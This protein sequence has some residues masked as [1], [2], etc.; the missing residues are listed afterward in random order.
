MSSTARLVL[1]RRFQPSIEGNYLGGEL[2]RKGLF[3]EKPSRRSHKLAL[4]ITVPIKIY[5][6]NRIRINM[7]ISYNDDKRAFLIAQA[8]D[9]LKPLVV[10]AETNLLL[11]AMAPW[12]RLKF[13]LVTHLLYSPEKTQKTRDITNSRA[14]EPYL[15]YTSKDP[16]GIPIGTFMNNDVRSKLTKEITKCSL[17][18][19][20]FSVYL[21][22]FSFIAEKSIVIYAVAT[23][24][25]LKKVIR[26]L[27]DI[28][29]TGYFTAQPSLDDHWQQE[30]YP[31]LVRIMF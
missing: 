4:T 8:S 1:N 26:E 10:A 25:F 22:Y 14:G 7:Y 21:Q 18:N 23:T 19:R 2:L 24:T 13:I 5:F 28:H 15:F 9:D 11:F 6:A 20:I 3:T 31:I 16:P 27:Q 17:F 12:E 29:E 30:P